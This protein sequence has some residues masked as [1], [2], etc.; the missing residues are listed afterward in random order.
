[1]SEHPP[2]PRTGAGARCSPARRARYGAGIVGQAQA[3][4]PQARGAQV[5]RPPNKINSLHDPRGLPRPIWTFL[6]IVAV[7]LGL[8]FSV[9][10]I[11]LA[12]DTR[13]IK[14]NRGR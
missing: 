10:L 4:P 2:S 9:A 8:E 7:R 1:M 5:A 3:C 12:E 14:A 11:R 13:D 6:V